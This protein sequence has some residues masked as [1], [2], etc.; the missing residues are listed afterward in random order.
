MLQRA[1]MPSSPHSGH[2]HRKAASGAN[3]TAGRAATGAAAKG[4]GAAA[5]RR[6]LTTTATATERW[7][8]I[9]DKLVA[10]SSVPFSILVL[11]QVV[12]V[13]WPGSRQGSQVR[14]KTRRTPF[15][16]RLLTSYSPAPHCSSSSAGPTDTIS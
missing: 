14:V 12:Q 7:S 16:L 11:P 2:N 6:P 3:G 13:G 9:T 8:H 1:Q 5:G 4:R 10:A 15:P